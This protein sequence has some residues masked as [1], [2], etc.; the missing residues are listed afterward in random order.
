MKRA[1]VMILLFAF[2]SVLSFQT[3]NAMPN[4]NL[5]YTKTTITLHETVNF[6]AQVSYS[7]NIT[8][9]CDDVNVQSGFSTSSNYTFIP[10]AVG[11]YYIKLSVNG[12][13][14]PPPIGAT[15]VTVIE[16]QTTSPIPSPTL[17]P[18]PTVPESPPWTIPLLLTIM[19][20]SAGLLVYQK[21]HN[22][23]K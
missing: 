1:V 9:F 3:A 11:V 12:F 8:W 15:K 13:T 18:T 23:H 5:D 21:K 6:T 19:V 16:V 17:S 20:A 22:K 7:A 4:V 2:G 10:K 14:N